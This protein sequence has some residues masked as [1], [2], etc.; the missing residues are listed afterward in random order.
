MEDDL[1]A[2][3]QTRAGWTWTADGT[4]ATYRVDVWSATVRK[5]A[6]PTR[7]SHRWQVSVI[8]PD[9]AAAWSGPAWTAVEAVRLAERQVRGF[10]SR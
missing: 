9:G 4:V 6:I 1:A 3:I 5:P 7:P 2:V 10:A 8:H